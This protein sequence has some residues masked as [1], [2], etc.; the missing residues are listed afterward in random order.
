MLKLKLHQTFKWKKLN[1][2]IE[3]VDKIALTA[4]GDKRTCWIEIYSYGINI[5]R[6]N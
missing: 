1:V 6:K 4:N 5:I 2:F 3:E